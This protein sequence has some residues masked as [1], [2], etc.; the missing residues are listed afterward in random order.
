LPPERDRTVSDQTLFDQE[1]QARQARRERQRLVN[2]CVER[3]TEDEGVRSE[4]DDGPAEALLLWAVGWLEAAAAHPSADSLQITRQAEQLR[5]ILRLING[6]IGRY[7]RTPD[8]AFL[9]SAL[10]R[11]LVRLHAF[12]PDHFPAA[13]L[14]AAHALLADLPDSADLAAG[15]LSVLD[16]FQPPAPPDDDQEETLP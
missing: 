8:P 11:L 3:F 15:V 7:T 1:R 12:A 2:R 5:T 16:T 6:M 9:R 4:I 10:N 14:A 13:T